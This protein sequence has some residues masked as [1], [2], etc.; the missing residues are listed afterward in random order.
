MPC[1]TQ[2]HD[3]G[4]CPG[5]LHSGHL[6]DTQAWNRTTAGKKQTRPFLISAASRTMSDKNTVLGMIQTLNV[7]FPH[8]HLDLRDIQSLTNNELGNETHHLRKRNQP[9]NADRKCP[10]N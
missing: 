8:K 3:A 1:V 5:R 4:A 10:G 9:G 6:L 2:A 7:S